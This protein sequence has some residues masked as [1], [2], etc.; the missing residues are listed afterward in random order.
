MTPRAADRAS[1]DECV[2]LEAARVLDHVMATTLRDVM[3]NLVL[4]SIIITIA[5]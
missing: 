4:V 1:G 2:W 3:G 5:G